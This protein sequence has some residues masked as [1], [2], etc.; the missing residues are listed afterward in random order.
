[1]KTIV[2]T[3]AAGKIGQILRRRWSDGRFHLRL[4]DVRDLGNIAAH[5]SQFLGDLRDPDFCC[6]LLQ[7]AD[8]VVHLAAVSTDQELGVL[9]EHN[10]K[11]LVSVYEAA[12]VHKVRVIYASSHHVVG[13]YS[14][15]EMVDAHAQ[16]RPDSFYGL[17]KVWGEAIARMYF[18]KH[19]VHSIC[20]RIGSCEKEPM[21][22]RHL[23]SWLSYED[24]GHLVECSIDATNIEFEIVYGVSANTRAWWQI[25][26]NLIGYRPVSNA[27]DFVSKVG[28]VMTQ[29]GPIAELFHGGRFAAANYSKINNSD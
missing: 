5:E 1:M 7:S 16:L 20:L 9:I 2:V 23:Y 27:E 29:G 21:D 8:A 24:M 18:D 11:A 10:L 17:S 15:N 3:G 14:S 22:R 28:D 25:S 4:N 19:G 6:Q 12:R 13:M 26:N